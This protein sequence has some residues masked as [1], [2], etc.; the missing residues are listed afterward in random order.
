MGRNKSTSPSHHLPVFRMG[1]T[2]QLL[3]HST[4]GVGGPTNFVLSSTRLCVAHGLQLAMVSCLSVRIGIVSIL[5][6]RLILSSLLT[7]LESRGGLWLDT[8]FWC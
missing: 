5:I 6:L 2:N 8:G 7:V 4:I 1:E 3:P